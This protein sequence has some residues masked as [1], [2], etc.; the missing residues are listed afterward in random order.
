MITKIEAVNYRC[1]A[2]V[3]Q[4]LGNFHV[5]TGPIGSG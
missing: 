1:L 5:I 4:T 2:S 3:S